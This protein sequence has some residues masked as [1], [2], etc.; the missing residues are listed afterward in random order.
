MGRKIQ[1]YT[2]IGGDSVQSILYIIIFDMRNREL[3]KTRSAHSQLCHRGGENATRTVQL[4][5]VSGKTLRELS[6][7]VFASRVFS[8]FLGAGGKLT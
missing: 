7:T 8:W 5:T 6:A 2:A 4:P 3:F 1:N